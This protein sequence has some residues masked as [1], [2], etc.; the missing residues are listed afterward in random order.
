MA[1]R[2]CATYGGRCR[3]ALESR[4]SGAGQSRHSRLLHRCVHGPGRLRWQRRGLEGQPDRNRK[5]DFDL[6]RRPH[7]D[8]AAD[9]A[10]DGDAGEYQHCSAAHTFTFSFTYSDRDTNA[11]GFSHAGDRRS[12]LRGSSSLHRNLHPHDARRLLQAFTRHRRASPGWLVRGRESRSWNARV[13]CLRRALRRNTN[14]HTDRH[15]IAIAYHFAVT[16]RFTSSLRRRQSLP[17]RQVL[18][19][20][21]RCLHHEPGYRDLCRRTER[22]SRGF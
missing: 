12:L 5:P 6:D 4:I 10:S 9:P 1:S 11:P 14:A 8:I 13:Q 17:A 16:Y 22:L 21:G 3:S 18:R 19:A 7:R 2:Q 15:A 20:S